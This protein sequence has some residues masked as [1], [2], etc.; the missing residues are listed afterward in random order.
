M[1][2][3]QVISQRYRSVL[4]K[5]VTKFYDQ[6]RLV[7]PSNKLAGHTGVATWTSGQN[8][9]TVT[10]E[11][12]SSDALRAGLLRVTYE[13]DIVGD[14]V[15]L[16]SFATS[17][18]R[19]NSV[20]TGARHS[21]DQFSYLSESPNNSLWPC[22]AVNQP[23]EIELT[24][25]ATAPLSDSVVI[26]ELVEDA[27]QYQYEFAQRIVDKL[28]SAL[29]IGKGRAARKV[30]KKFRPRKRGIRSRLKD[31]ARG[32]WKR[33]PFVA[34]VGDMEPGQA[35]GEVLGATDA[36]INELVDE[37]LGA[38]EDYESDLLEETMGALG[39]VFAADR[40]ETPDDDYDSDL[41]GVL[42]SFF[43]DADE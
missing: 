35:I 24:T 36:G 2:R 7:T 21:V 43:L 38:V 1:A 32:I 41:A 20:E 37:M 39:E 17:A 25:L 34:G 3:K 31:V 33:L 13:R 9:V 14:L 16:T 8:K 6:R 40:V 12:K 26:V 28:M 42:G 15:V 10:I 30:A 18:D 11:T 29:V 22:P 5:L 23:V 27:S 4:E 19:A